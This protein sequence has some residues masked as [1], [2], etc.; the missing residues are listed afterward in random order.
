MYD[1]NDIFNDWN[2][3]KKQIDK[4]ELTVFAKPRHI[5]YIKM[6]YNI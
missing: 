5:C 2:R 4:K 6:G 3:E 1:K